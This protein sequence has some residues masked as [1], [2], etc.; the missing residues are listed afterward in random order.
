MILEHSIT[1]DQLETL[2][3]INFFPNLPDDVE[4]TVEASFSAAAWGL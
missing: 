4:S 1:I 2:T 3:G